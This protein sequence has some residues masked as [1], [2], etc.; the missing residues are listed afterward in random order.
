MKLL[1]TLDVHFQIVIPK[2]RM[3]LKHPELCAMVPFQQRPT[4]MQYSHF[5]TVDQFPK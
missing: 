3:G 1:K 5:Q 2:V 4:D